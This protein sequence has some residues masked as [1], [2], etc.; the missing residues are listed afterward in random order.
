MNYPETFAIE[1]NS[2]PLTMTINGK[3]YLSARGVN[4]SGKPWEEAGEVV[5][6]LLGGKLGVAVLQVF[7][8]HQVRRACHF[9]YH[10]WVWLHQIEWAF[11]DDSR[12][13]PLTKSYG[14][15]EGIG[16]W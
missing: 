1:K 6:H 11:L 4:H 14:H 9:A 2:F 16:L 15:L 13:F 8:L 3:G 7:A 12:L 5:F 10:D